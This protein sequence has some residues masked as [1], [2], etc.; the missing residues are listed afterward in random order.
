MEGY[1]ESTF[2]KLVKEEQDAIHAIIRAN[3]DID[4]AEVMYD[5]I[6]GSAAGDSNG[7]YAT[8]LRLIPGNMEEPDV[9]PEPLRTMPDAIGVFKYVT[10]LDLEKHLIDTIPG[11]IGKMEWLQSLW[12]CASTKIVMSGIGRA[13]MLRKIDGFLIH[14][15]SIPDDIIDLGIPPY[16]DSV[17]NPD[18]KRGCNFCESKIIFTEKQK[19]WAKVN[20]MEEYR[21]KYCPVV[22]LKEFE[23]RVKRETPINARFN[24][25]TLH[26]TGVDGVM[27]SEIHIFT[28]NGKLVDH[29]SAKPFPLSFSMNVNKTI[30]KGHYFVRLKS[31]HGYQ[32]TRFVVP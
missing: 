30:S 12:L 8:S 31:N 14:L 24:R 15:R 4:S 20:N 29:F 5:R 11:V 21:Q 9:L 27:V 18:E 3:K 22:A 17:T 32:F 13:P 25:G 1:G 28:A 6:I 10:T 2:D 19:K 23:S 26:I 7:F 16:I